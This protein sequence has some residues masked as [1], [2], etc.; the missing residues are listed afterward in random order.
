M[1]KSDRGNLSLSSRVIAPLAT[2]VRLLPGCRP[3]AVLGRVPALV[4]DTVDTVARRR[5]RSHVSIK[6]C[7]VAPLRAHRDPA[8]AVIRVALVAGVAAPLPHRV[9]DVI[10]RDAISKAVPTVVI[11]PGFALATSARYGLPASERAAVSRADRAAVASADPAGIL[12]G[13]RR[14]AEVPLNDDQSPESLARFV[15]DKVLEHRAYLSVSRPRSFAATRG[16]RASN[17]TPTR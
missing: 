7:E 13:I 14:G 16:L 9:P 4:V 15:C 2:V 11:R 8:T 12:R 10:L 6:G 5:A 17:C 3:S 1:A